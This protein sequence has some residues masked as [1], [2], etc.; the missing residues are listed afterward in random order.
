[1]LGVTFFFFKKKGIHMEVLFSYGVG[2]G[3]QMDGG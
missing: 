3:G 1:M 2:R